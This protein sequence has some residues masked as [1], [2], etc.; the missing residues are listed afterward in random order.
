MWKQ[1][2]KYSSLFT[3]P[4]GISASQSVKE[5]VA[6]E[7]NGYG[8]DYCIDVSGSVENAEECVEI[9]AKCGR[10]LYAAS[11]DFGD[12][13][14]NLNLFTARCEKELSIVTCLLYTSRCV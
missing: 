12:R 2:R 6:E 14:M 9:V 7:T 11:Y 10:I 1:T 4:S 13:P 3:K 8:V 5:I